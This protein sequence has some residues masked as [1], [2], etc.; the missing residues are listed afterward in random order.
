MEGISQTISKAFSAYKKYILETVEKELREW[1]WDLL[2]AAIL[3][4]ERNRGAH[5]FTGNFLNSITVCLYR[6]NAPVIAYYSSSLV[7]DAIR[8]KMSAPK[9]S[10]FK[11]DYE[12]A[13]SV[14][15]PE[16]ATNR[17]WSR[18]DA[19]AFFESYSPRGK[20]LFDIVVAYTAEYAGFIEHERQTTGILQ[21][22]RQARNTGIKFMELV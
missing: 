3:W 14:Y 2:N 12:G 16:V 17:G 22:W 20:N 5:D 1:C 15:K 19:E 7:P 8:P 11:R 6:K 4:R 10:Y 9:R 18:D 13:R 21:T